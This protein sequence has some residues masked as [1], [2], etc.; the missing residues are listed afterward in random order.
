MRESLIQDQNLA[1]TQTPGKK[2]KVKELAEV[3]CVCITEVISPRSGVVAFESLSK[4]RVFEA[5]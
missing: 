4:G 5:P 3:S 1:L 2:P